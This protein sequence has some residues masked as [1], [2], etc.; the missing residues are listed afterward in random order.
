MHSIYIMGI[1]K[2]L[3][4]YAQNY[5]RGIMSVMPTTCY[6]MTVKKN[7]AQRAV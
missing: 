5:M 2:R 3:H 4:Y 1:I 6:K 7:H